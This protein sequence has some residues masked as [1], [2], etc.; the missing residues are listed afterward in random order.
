MNTFDRQIARALDTL[1]AALQGDS[2]ALREETLDAVRELSFPGLLAVLGV[3]EDAAG[4]RGDTLLRAAATTLAAAPELREAG[5][6]PERIERMLRALLIDRSAP[7]G[8]AQERAR[9]AVVA[10]LAVAALSERTGLA[11]ADA[12]AAAELLGSGEFF[13]DVAASTAALLHAVPRLPLALVRDVAGLPHR[14]LRLAAALALDLVGTPFQVPVVLADLLDGSLDHPPTVLRRTL[15]AL[16]GFA[17]LAAVLETLRTL[18][19]PENRSLRLAVLV[20]ARA[21]GI[22]LEDSDLDRVRELFAPDSPGL[23]PALVAGIER[24]RKHEGAD[25]ALR[26][27]RRLGQREE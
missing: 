19:A 10:R 25:G 17:S 15:S 7:A 1:H 6:S 16:Y 22:P 9:A 20:Y 12:R 13:G 3:S 4:A 5:I 21:N 18:L 24:L 8:D 2:R 26:I 14:S 27:L 23:G 11:P